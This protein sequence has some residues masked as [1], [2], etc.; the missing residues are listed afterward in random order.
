MLLKIDAREKELI[1]CCQYILEMSPS[2]KEVQLVVEALPLGDIILEKEGQEKVII[3]RKSIRDLS[4]SIKDGRYEEQSFRLNGYPM[5]NHNIVYLIEGDLNKINMFKDRID[6]MTL[7]SAM[8]SLFYFKGFSV[9]RTVS[10]EETANVLCNM[11]YKIEKSESDGKKAFYSLR[12]KNVA[13]SLKEELGLVKEENYSSV[14]KKVKKEN[15]TPE[16][17]GEIMLSQIP[18]ISSVTASEI[19]T[20]FKNLPNL[21]TALKE[22]ESCLENFSYTNTKGQ[23]RKMNKTIVTNLKKFLKTDVYP[24]CNETSLPL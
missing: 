21:I 12:E 1:Q 3:E 17:I 6:K 11:A 22:N 19:M 5:E 9:L 23:T 14:V 15:I 18:G 7:Y 8:I 16:N 2:Y 10:I 24:T 20:K 4:A 13:D